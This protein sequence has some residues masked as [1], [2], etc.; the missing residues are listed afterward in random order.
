MYIQEYYYLMVPY[1]SRYI[2]LNQLSAYIIEALHLFFI[3][4]LFIHMSSYATTI[5]FTIL[6]AYMYMF[7]FG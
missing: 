5:L 1:C 3:Y 2:L 6:T 7:V 4:L